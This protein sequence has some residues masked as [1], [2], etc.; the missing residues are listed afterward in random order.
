MS[1]L[2][3]PRPG[4]LYR[5]R[6]VAVALAFG[7][8]IPALA[9]FGSPANAGALS[10]GATATPTPAVTTSRAT[11]SPSRGATTPSP[12]ATS[13]SS[14]GPTPSAGPSPSSSASPSASVRPSPTPG[15]SGTLAIATW[16]V[17]RSVAGATPVRYAYRLTTA[18]TSELTSIT[19]TV[20][21]GTTGRPT[22]TSVTPSDV[23]GGAVARSGA[24][25]IYSFTPTTVHAGAG[26]TLE[27]SGMTNTDAAGRF[28]STITTRD[29]TAVVET[30]STAEIALAPAPT[31]PTVSPSM[32]AG[33]SQPPDPISKPPPRPDAPIVPD[34]TLTG[35][36]WTASTTRTGA[37]GVSY[38]YT[39]TTLTVSRLNRVT[40]TLPTGTGGS[41]AVGTVTPA[42]FASGGSVSRSGTTLT[43]RFNAINNNPA[44]TAV[45][46]RINGLTNTSTAGTYTSTIRVQ[47]NSNVIDT[48]TTAGLTFTVLGPLAVTVPTS[49]AWAAT[50]TGVNKNVVDAR[51]ADQQL[52]VN[53][54]TGT[55]AGWRLTVSAT[56]FT[57]G[58]R[59]L[60]NTG[61]LLSTGSLTSATATTPPTATCVTS[62]DLP[63]NT[64]AYPVAITTAPSAPAAVRLYTSAAG[65]GR[66]SVRIGGSTASNPLGWWVRVPGDAHS[67]A[68]TSTITVAVVS[69]P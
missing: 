13:T 6:V 54:P 32:S 20:P 14:R 49:L 65:T 18:S 29:D 45:S 4:W 58:T 26:I 5:H 53:D 48:G 2:T 34:A 7:C 1:G 47:N 50:L 40:M 37:T 39:F 69:G 9:G 38:T 27:I 42:S 55:G 64:T 59:T 8:L 56:T 44:G 61:T 16:S 10:A 25:L 12:T 31:D 62:C 22:V 17:S 67:G 60:P 24:T 51:A 11:T 30:G 19:A 41:P 36:T 43:Y 33:P 66:G 35:P 63:T 57:N 3:P 46:I 15:S 21:A 28:V 23:A 68:Y 52:V